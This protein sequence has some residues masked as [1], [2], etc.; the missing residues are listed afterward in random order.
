[1]SVSQTRSITINGTANK[2][3]CISR[4]ARI[5][6]IK[7]RLTRRAKNI[8]RP[9]GECLG[10]GHPKTDVERKARVQGRV[11][12]HIG[13]HPK[14]AG[15]RWQSTLRGENARL[16]FHVNEFYKKGCQEKSSASTGGSKFFLEIQPTL[17]R[18]PEEGWL[19]VPF[20]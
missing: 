17:F 7:Y 15:S 11:P 5:D 19:V 20:S 16:D 18:Y 12:Q 1:M 9:R 6:R 14:R 10:K 2:W 3:L 13:W 8:F 4:V